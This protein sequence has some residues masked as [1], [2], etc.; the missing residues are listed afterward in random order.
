MMNFVTELNKSFYIHKNET[1][2]EKQ[3][4]YLKHK[5]QLLGIKTPQ[6]KELQKPFLSKNS[7]P[8]KENLSDITIKLWNLPSREFQYVAIDL[9]RLYLR[10]MQEKDIDIFE[11]MITS[12]SWWDSVDLIAVNL[13]GHYFKL[14]P[15]NKFEIIDKWMSSE[16]I[17]LHRTCLIFQLKYKQETDLELL[18]QIIEP[19]I[20]TKEFFINKAIGWIL[21]EY[22]RTNPEWVVE[23]VDKHELSN[24]SR[25][26]ALRL[27]D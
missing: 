9:N 5:F 23:F 15:Q 11:C 2:A 6:R 16:N 18:A 10:Q 8:K 13:V 24:L 20:G 21:R 17:W 25:K 4:A 1:V 27:I 22:S 19:L 12:K 26:E 14:F 3:E 7:R